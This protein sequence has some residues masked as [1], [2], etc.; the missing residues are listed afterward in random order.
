MTLQPDGR[1]MFPAT[2][3]LHENPNVLLQSHAVFCVREGKL[4]ASSWG[5]VDE[6]IFI[7]KASAELRPRLKKKFR[8]ETKVIYSNMNYSSQLH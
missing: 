6:V 2:P 7:V 5:E 1:R 4:Q 3:N 8:S